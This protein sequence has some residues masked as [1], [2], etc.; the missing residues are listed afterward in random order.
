MQKFFLKFKSFCLVSLSVI[1][2]M[3]IVFLFRQALVSDK[4][5]KMTY[6]EVV[7]LNNLPID[8]NIALISIRD[9]ITPYSEVKK[10]VDVDVKGLTKTIS[11]LP[12]VEN[13]SVIRD[14]P[15]VIKIVI[16]SK[17]FI[18]YKVLNDKYYPI[19]SSGEVLNMPVE[20]AD[21]LL[22]FGDGAETEV[23]NL[24]KFLSKYP[25]L[26]NRLGAIQYVNGLRWNLIFYDVADGLTAKLDNDFEK[27]VAK[28]AELDVLQG[29]LSRDISDIDLRDLTKI[30]IKQ[31]KN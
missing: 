22:V 26:K 1:S 19:T 11:E 16:S 23:L 15:D 4:V 30:L 12:W 27:G 5:F 7:F 31:R 13:V 29:I 2:L 14:F 8:K 6:P 25:N 21:G 9:L 20:Y 3:T 18:A 24:L 17:Q 10:I 28:L